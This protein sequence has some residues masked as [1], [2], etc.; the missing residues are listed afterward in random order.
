[1]S[2]SIGLT[3]IVRDIK[4]ECR[5]HDVFWHGLHISGKRMIKIGYDGGSRGDFDTGVMLGADICSLIPLALPAVNFEGNQI[6]N[7]VKDWMGADYLAPLTAEGWFSMGHQTGKHFW[8]PPPAGAL[9]ALEELA[10]SKLKRPFEVTHVFLCPRLLYFEEWRRRFEKEMDFW[11]LIDAN[12]PFWPNS[13]CDPLVL[14][15]S[16]P[17]R[18]ERPWKLR[19]EPKVVDVGRRVQEMLKDGADLA[20]RNIW[21]KLWIDP[22]GLFGL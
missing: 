16:F 21:R 2:K 19:G 17:L 5:K 10:Q 22:W 1:M 7:W 11:F 6:T 9:I 14:G 15:I 12:I 8:A 13:C 18:R 3:D 4:Y 20:V